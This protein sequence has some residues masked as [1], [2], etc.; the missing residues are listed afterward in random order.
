VQLWPR[1][2]AVNHAVDRGR[3]LQGKPIQVHSLPSS[4]PPS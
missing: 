3:A 2:V 4:F 1:E